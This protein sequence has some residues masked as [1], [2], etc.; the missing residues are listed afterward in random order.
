MRV[1]VGVALAL[2]L[3]AGCSGGSSENA[4]AVA[5][6]EAQTDGGRW[7]MLAVQA[8]EVEFFHSL[9]EMGKI[10]DVVVIA[11]ATKVDGVRRVGPEGEEGIDLAQ[12]RFEVIRAVS[13]WDENSIT[14]DF[15]VPSREA[16][17]AL[18]EQVAGFPPAVLAVRDKGTV[19]ARWAGQFQLVNQESLWTEQPGGGLVA[20]L[21]QHDALDAEGGGGVEREF[22]S[23]LAEIKTLDDLGGLLD[24]G[25][26]ECDGECGL[27]QAAWNR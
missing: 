15:Y 2:L 6:N 3:A 17:K 10:A 25:R 14:L 12:V 7:D 23:E 19:E 24:A 21:A 8:D 16:L 4:A 20:P 26:R 9:A 13:D 5:A 1:A 27:S 11:Q 22:A 18:E